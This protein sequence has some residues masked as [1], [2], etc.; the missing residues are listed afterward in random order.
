MSD[1]S[2]RPRRRLGCLARLLILVIFMGACYW[3]L[4]APIS[5]GGTGQTPE[6]TVEAPA[7][8]LNIE[9]EVNSTQ[10]AA[11][12]KM[13]D[14]TGE[15]VD[16]LAQGGQIRFLDAAVQVPDSVAVSP[17]E[18]AAYFFSQN[19]S[20]IQIQNPATSLFPV[21]SSTNEQGVTTLRY[22][23]KYK[24]I[25]VYGSSIVISLGSNDSVL[26]FSATYVPNL[27]MDVQP[28]IRSIAAE[29]V[30]LST[31]GNGDAQLFGETALV[32]Y[33]PEIWSPNQSVMEPTL[34]WLVL[35]GSEAGGDLSIF[36]VNAKTGN[37]LDRISLFVEIGGQP[38]IEVRDAQGKTLENTVLFGWKD[39]K[40]IMDEN[41]WVSGATHDP[42]A[43][44]IQQNAHRVYGYYWNAF[45]RDSY[46]NK[47]MRIKVFYDIDDCWPRWLK[48]AQ[49][50]GLPISLPVNSIFM[51][52]DWAENIDAMAHE[53]THG[54]IA[55]SSNLVNGGESSALNEAYADIFAALIDDKDPWKNTWDVAGTMIR[56]RL[57][58]P[59]AV[60]PDFPVV[61]ADLF[62]PKQGEG[63]PTE[64]DDPPCPHTNS[65][66]WS[67]AF[68]LLAVGDMGIHPNLPGIDLDKLEFIYYETMIN[69][70][71]GAGFK[72]A[73]RNTLSR[74]ISFSANQSLGITDSDCEAMQAI[75][76]NTGLVEP[77]IPPILP[78]VPELPTLPTLPELPNFTELINNLREELRNLVDDLLG[79]WSPIKLW[80]PIQ[81]EIDRIRNNYWVK[82]LEC[83]K[84]SDQACIDRYWAD[85]INAVFEMIMNTICNFC[86]S[87]FILPVV[88]FAFRR[89]RRTNF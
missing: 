83:I 67:H 48:D 74:C 21:G 29:Q 46:D 6:T 59:K 58:E 13:A 47:G 45:H 11:L 52:Q 84:N 28:K 75:F 22:E 12:E 78:T 73:A 89:Q 49:L 71:S 33:A 36:I 15:Q 25:P 76:V 62:I 65:T 70:P 61:Y 34:S 18:K 14:D 63:C 82:L 40:L 88:V 24:G 2:Y 85:F 79:D 23:Q 30:V 60:D 3:L 19:S 20:L 8:G 72:D 55:H 51:C 42:T 66:I 41:G 43:E 69:L 9:G 50:I 5:E 87:L 68:Y 37:M 27:E 53:F 64:M 57:D 77:P 39:S 56:R 81:A 1:S 16:V 26:S 31:L 44:F 10:R 38:K 80:E 32:I 86:S 4:L 17:Q 7:E 35:A 54:V